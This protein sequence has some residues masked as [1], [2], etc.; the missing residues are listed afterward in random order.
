MPVTTKLR[1]VFQ[2][3]FKALPQRISRA[4]GRINLIGE[5][6]DYNDGLVLPA[7]IDKY[8][9]FALATNNSPICNIYSLDSD[10]SIT[11]DLNKE[12]KPVTPGH[13]ATYVTGVIAVMRQEG[14]P[15]N[16]FNA[17]FTA[18]IP[19]GAG[20]SSSAALEVALAYGLAR[21]SGYTLPCEKI[22]FI[23]QQAEQQFAGV[24]CGIMDQFASCRGKAGHLLKLDCRSLAY[25][26]IGAHLG[27]YQLVLYDTGVKHALAT[28]AYNQRQ[29]ECAAGVQALQR[30][31]PQVKALRDATLPMLSAI[32]QLVA[33]AVYNRCRY[34]VEENQRVLAAAAALTAGDLPA[35]GK[36]M[37][38]SH[39][40]LSGLYAV[41]CP[42]LDYLVDLVKERQEVPGARM[43]GGGFGGC[44]LNLIEANKA[45][46]ITNYLKEKYFTRTGIE[47]KAYSV[48]LSAGVRL[49][50]S[51]KS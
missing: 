24:A 28:T 11:L 9:Y 38:A 17:V 27:D 43:M 49:V 6:T 23:G 46:A 34:V 51:R 22:A 44:T 5:H 40:G 35:V 47:L 33:K 37:Y 29:K 8:M 30:F 31:Y 32:R 4:P 18:N 15:I 3:R 13:W 20:L 14:Y 36:L 21:L 16:G 7:A 41:S 10:E 12:L 50:Y 1:E 26:H 39:Q 48:T 45:A 19:L 25:E 42:E 2:Q